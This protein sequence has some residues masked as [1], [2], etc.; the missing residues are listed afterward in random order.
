MADKN[1]WSA[2]VKVSGGKSR[3]APKHGKRSTK[4]T[5]HRTARGMV[6]GKTR[7]SGR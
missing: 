7:S 6:R 3:L 4:S 1:G 2:A 5:K